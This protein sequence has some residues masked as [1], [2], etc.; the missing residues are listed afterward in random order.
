MLDVFKELEAKIQENDNRVR[1]YGWQQFPALFQKLYFDGSIL[2][3]FIKYSSRLVSRKWSAIGEPIIEIFDIIGNH[4]NSI[5]YQNIFNF[6]F[7][8]L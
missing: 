8:C 7:K 6:S 1:L 4:S 2:P 3:L 5:T